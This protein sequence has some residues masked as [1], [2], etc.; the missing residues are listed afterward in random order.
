MPG[1]L[2][3]QKVKKI[4]FQVDSNSLRMPVENSMIN[5]KTIKNSNRRRKWN[6]GEKNNLIKPR[7]GKKE[8]EME[9]NR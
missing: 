3:F 2:H 4:V 8:K 9:Q 1:T 5:I 6:K 7:E